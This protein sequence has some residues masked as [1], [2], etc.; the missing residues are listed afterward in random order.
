M[1]AMVLC[2]KLRVRKKTKKVITQC[3]NVL[4][5]LQ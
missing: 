2:L 5:W 4:D 3:M 1:S